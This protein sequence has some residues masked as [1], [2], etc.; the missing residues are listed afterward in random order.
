MSRSSQYS[1]MSGSSR[2]PTQPEIIETNPMRHMRHIFW[3]RR[4]LNGIL[5]NFTKTFCGVNKKLPGNQPPE[6]QM[7]WALRIGPYIHELLT[8]KNANIQW[9]YVDDR[10]GQG[11]SPSMGDVDL[12]Q[13]SATD[14][15][16]AALGK[17]QRLSIIA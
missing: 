14:T 16:L 4:W 7:H 15:E 6:A 17:F 9:H 13:T 8:D 5:G 11:W 2:H 3:C 1:L 10:Q 12:G